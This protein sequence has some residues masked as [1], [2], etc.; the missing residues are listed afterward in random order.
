MI[1]VRSAICY[2]TLLVT[3]CLSYELQLVQASLLP[4]QPALQDLYQ[5]DQSSE[6]EYLNDG[7]Y[8]GLLW[9]VVISEIILMG[10]LAMISIMFMC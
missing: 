9:F 5:T 3:M 6:Y 7:L 1:T 2:S 4:P 8:G 10:S